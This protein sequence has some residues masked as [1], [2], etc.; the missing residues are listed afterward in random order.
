[1]NLMIICKNK[2]NAKF[3]INNKTNRIADWIAYIRNNC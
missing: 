3:R 1:M 2:G